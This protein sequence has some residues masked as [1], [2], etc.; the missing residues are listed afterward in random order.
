LRA[1]T[2]LDGL[3]QNAG[4]RFQRTFADE[5]LLE[6]L[7]LMPRD[8]LVDPD[9]RTKCN[10]LYRQ[11][12]VSYKN[13]T[14]LDKIATLYK[15]LP[16][17]KKRQPSQSKVVRETEQEAAREAQSPP[18]SRARAPS[19][20]SSS[21]QK[22]APPRPPPVVLAQT[23]SSSFFSRSK[24]KKKG[25]EIKF[26]LEKEKGRIME[27]IAAANVASTNL[28]NGIKLINRENQRVSENAECRNRFDQ[29]K[30]LR[31]QILRYIQLV[32]SEQYIGGLLS[33][34]DELVKALMAYEVMDKSIEDDSD[35]DVE[36]LES[37]A[38]RMSGGQNQEEAMAGLS[39]NA[40]ASSPPKPGRS[41][42]VP[43]VPTPAPV[44]VKV[45]SSESEEEPDIEDDDEDNP[46]ADRN[47]LGTT[48]VGKNGLTW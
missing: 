18:P 43:P 35:S 45:E 47:A 1:L 41:T 23:S 28:I 29:S 48:N 4:P 16:Q 38:R 13:V 37:K 17:T 32:E 26:N 9:V 44:P 21:R 39:L 10:T 22:S 46:F 24:D 7:R 27:T 30:T 6:R 19:S 15:Q 5:P 31:R 3:I 8:D 42:F 12:A 33:A 40:V 20:P 14:G 11:W 36:W 25:A 2:I 34:N